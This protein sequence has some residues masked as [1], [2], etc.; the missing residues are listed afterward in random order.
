MSAIDAVHGVGVTQMV[1]PV[2]ATLALLLTPLAGQAR[3]FLK[4]ATGGSCEILGVASGATL[5]AADLSTKTGTGWP[6]ETSVLSLEGPTRCY[7]ASL[8]VTS[9]VHVLRGNSAGT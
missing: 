7:L 8:G 9:T 6:L 2:G 5:T 1:V 4:M 3:T